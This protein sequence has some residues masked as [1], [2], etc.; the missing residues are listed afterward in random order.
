MKKKTLMFGAC[1]LLIHTNLSSPALSQERQQDNAWQETSRIVHSQPLVTLVLASSATPQRLAIHTIQ[2]PKLPPSPALQIPQP[3][4][5]PDL[6]ITSLQWSH[7][8]KEGDNV[9]SPNTLTIIV[10]N[11]GAALA[12]PCQVRITCMASGTVC[13]S[14]LSGLTP[15]MPL[16]AGASTSISWPNVRNDTWSAGKYMITAEIDALKEVSESDEQNNSMTLEFVVA[17]IPPLTG[18]P[19]ASMQESE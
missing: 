1:L 8:L 15:C 5:L 12:G 16:A 2:I 11:Q 14:E 4:P 3:K 19:P 10:K 13:P 6:I 9:G 17:A 18:I 7:P